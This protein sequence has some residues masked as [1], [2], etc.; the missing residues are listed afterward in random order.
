MNTEVK[1]VRYFFYS[2][3]F[4]DGLKMSFGIL[5][6]TLLLSYLGYFNTGL[7]LSLGALCVCLADSPGPVIH[8]KNGMLICS[9]FVFLVSLITIYARLNTYTLGLEIIA[10]TFFFSMFNVYGNRA[11]LVGN[12]SILIMI[13]TMDKPVPLSQAMPSA[14]LL[15]G[16][17]IFYTLLSLGFYKLR[18]YRIAQRILG[19]CVREVAAYLMIKAD[20]YDTHIDLNTSYK[21]LFA[22]Q[23]IVHEK[24]DACREVLFKTRQIIRE[25]T[26]MGRKLV[27]TFIETVDLFEDIT[28]T[29]YDYTVLRQTFPSNHILD[30]ISDSIRKMSFDL[31]QIGIAIQLNNSYQL[32]TNYDELL[33]ELKKQIDDEEKEHNTVILKKILVNIRRLAIRLKELTRYFEGKDFKRVK[34]DH[35]QF[36][37]HQSLDPKILVN[38]LNFQS[39]VFKHALRV[40]LACITGYLISKALAYGNHSYWIVMTIAFM[41]KPAFSLTKQRN[42][43]RVIGT[44]AGGVIGWMILYFIPDRN[45]HLAFLILFM[46]GT[47]SFMRINYL[48][49]V[50]CTTPYIL[51]LF[52]FLGLGFMEVAKERILDTA[53]GCAIALIAGYFLFPSWESAQIKNYLQNM[54]R[55]NIRYLGRI[56]DALNGKPIDLLQYKLA[57]KEV[58]VA[59]ANLSSAFQRMLSEPKNKQVN[60]KLV[61]QFVVL[62]HILLSNIATIITS[63]L[64]KE[65]SKHHEELAT[66]TYQ[67]IR[68]LEA[69]VKKLDGEH[70]SSGADW[71][72]ANQLN[73]EDQLLTEQL[74]FIY[75]LTIEIDKTVDGFNA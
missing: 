34:L 10:V 11:T 36:I 45:V 46:I 65:S 55:A 21:K 5:F 12:A 23:I 8:K 61:H 22:Q 50:I 72:P 71:L 15:F 26:M 43:E 6:P 59:S 39:N 73:G 29:Y 20:F 53:I 9:L 31:D 24:Q 32:S 47:Y 27:W 49:M 35:T 54:L 40:A 38:N 28:A 75:K 19:E 56:A 74:N 60:E 2:Q 16:G 48:V 33:S 58:Y 13:L 18:P 63:L 62:N 14:L 7:T 25:T 51:I 68:L 67:S 42:K 30:N 3:A 41:L 44:L 57:R 37:S 69:D 17:G 70:L 66:L 1:E 64:R 52:S 4:A